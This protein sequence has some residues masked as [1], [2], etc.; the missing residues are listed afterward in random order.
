MCRA[1]K[2]TDTILLLALLS[3]PTSHTGVSGNSRQ[4]R[5]INCNTVRF[6]VIHYLLFNFITIFILLKKTKFFNPQRY[7][8]LPAARRLLLQYTVAD[9]VVDSLN[10]QEYLSTVCWQG[11]NVQ[12]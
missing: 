10:L 11:A 7:T 2:K 9:Q 1:A 6:K 8:E 12:P 4:L 5:I 3:A